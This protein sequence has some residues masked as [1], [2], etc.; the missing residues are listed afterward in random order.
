MNSNLLPVQQSLSEKEST[1]KDN[2]DP[3]NFD[4][5]VALES[6]SLQVYN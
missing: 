1:I 2:I 6:I 4:V 3:S 5:V